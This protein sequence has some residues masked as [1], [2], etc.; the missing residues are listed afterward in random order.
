TTTAQPVA[1]GNVNYLNHD[2]SIRSWLLTVDHKRIGLLYM[3][4][5]ALVFL[6]AGILAL[7]VRI[8]LIAPGPTIVDAQTYNQL[9]SL[10]GIMMVF[11]FVVPGV[12]AILGNFMLPIQL[13]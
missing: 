6:A 13:G 10:H 7:L 2:K 9:F 8:E 11:L 1:S 4:S 3:G 12:P 5:I